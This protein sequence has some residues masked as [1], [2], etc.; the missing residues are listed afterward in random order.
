GVCLARCT[1]ELHPG[2]SGWIH[3]YSE[4]LEF[5]LFGERNSGLLMHS[6][7]LFGTF[8]FIFIPDCYFIRFKS[9]FTLFNADKD[10]E[11]IKKFVIIKTKNKND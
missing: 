10:L 5:L 7:V 4:I 8:F 6:G 2:P 9:K 1:G 11:E 3:L